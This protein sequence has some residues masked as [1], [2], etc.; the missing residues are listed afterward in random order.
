MLSSIFSNGN[1]RFNRGIAHVLSRIDYDAL[2]RGVYNAS[3]NPDKTHTI[4][5]FEYVN[6][7]VYERIAEKER[8]PET[9]QYIHEFLSQPEVD[10]ALKS[11]FTGKSNIKLYTRRK[12]D[13]AGVFTK[14]RQLIIRILPEMPSPILPTYSNYLDDDS[15][16]EDMPPLERIP[17]NYSR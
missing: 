15:D 13:G 1:A 2:Q 3:K 6:S 5:L 10:I 8:I 7:C 11:L 4:V 14:Y 16:Y 9:T 17:K 12:Q